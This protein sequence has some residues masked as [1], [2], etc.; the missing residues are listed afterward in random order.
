MTR[1]LL[2]LALA[3]CCAACEGDI[4]LGGPGRPD[5]GA[6]P[7]GPVAELRFRLAGGFAA[8]PAPSALATGDLDRD[9][10][11][12]VIVAGAAGSLRVL[13]GDRQGGLRPARDLALGA[14]APLALA[15]A[16]VDGDGDL[17]ALVAADQDVLVLPGDGAGGF[18]PRARHPLGTAPAALLAA[19]LTGDGVKDALVAGGQ[20]AAVLRGG[21]AGLAAPVWH[22]ACAGPV[23]L[24]AGDLAGSGRVDLAVGCGQEGV[25]VLLAQ[26]DGS[27]RRGGLYRGL[28]VGLQ[29]LHALDADIDG[30]PDLILISPRDSY[31]DLLLGVGGGGFLSDKFAVRAQVGLGPAALCAADLDRDGRPDLA[32]ALMSAQGVSVVLA[33][34][35]AGAGAGSGTWAPAVRAFPVG[36]P[37]TAVAAADLDRDG[38]IDLLL[39][40]RGVDEVLLLR[41]TSQ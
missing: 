40:R 32:A 5:G 6:P 23:A 34:A 25:Q 26:A 31:L 12:D 18:G 29:A 1:R 20:G 2:V 19:D 4:V 38:L 13:L 16:D 11:P 35:R 7:P 24:A 36:G 22:P 33:R 27:L 37:P 28:G 9:G 3:V 17:D 41:N 39:L 10:W 8:G 15:L 14:G 30:K 21:V